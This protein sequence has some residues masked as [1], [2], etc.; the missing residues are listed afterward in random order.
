MRQKVLPSRLDS[1]DRT[2]VTVAFRGVQLNGS[3]PNDAPDVTGRYH[4]ALEQSDD[5]AMGRT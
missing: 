1:S 3:V 5:A 2:A 4:L